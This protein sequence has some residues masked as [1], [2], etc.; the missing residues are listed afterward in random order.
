MEQRGTTQEPGGQAKRPETDCVN[1][2]HPS[3]VMFNHESVSPQKS[4]RAAEAEGG[5]RL[6]HQFVNV[7][8][9]GKSEA[10]SVTPE[11]R[12]SC[13]SHWIKRIKCGLLRAS[14]ISLDSPARVFGH[15]L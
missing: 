10:E 14:N 15:F 8:D 13:L 9:L 11:V 5:E 1:S 2:W 12:S 4:Q 7:D 6:V 3:R